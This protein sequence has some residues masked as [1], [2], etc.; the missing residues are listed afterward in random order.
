MKKARQ[1]LTLNEMI[2]SEQHV[3]PLKNI[4]LDI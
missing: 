3:S 2:N 1:I 4:K